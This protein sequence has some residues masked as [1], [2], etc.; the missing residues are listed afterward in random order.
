[1][2]HISKSIKKRNVCPGQIKNKRFSTKAETEKT[3]DFTLKFER[4]K[5]N[6]FHV[7]LP[8]DI[9]DDPVLNVK[10]LGVLTALE[11][12]AWPKDI[13]CPTTAQLREKTKL[14]NRGLYPALKKLK[15]YHYIDW[16][17]TRSVNIYLLV[18][19]NADPK[20]RLAKFKNTRSDWLLRICL[21]YTSPSPRDRTRSRMPS[22]A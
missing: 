12:F 19:K 21:L 11:R 3:S 14:S 1:M 9:I 7:Q 16:K 13:C 6:C 20:K 18:W 17:E 8:F 15:K 5:I 2:K 4:V 10:D 22:S